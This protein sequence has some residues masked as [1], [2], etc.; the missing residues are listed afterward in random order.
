MS[1]PGVSGPLADLRVLDLSSLLPGPY[2]TRILADL[3]ADVI[4]IES[5]WG[6]GARRM[7]PVAN[8]CGAAFATL[9][10]DKRSVVIDLKKAEGVALFV[11][12]AEHVQVVVESFRPGVLARLQLGYDVLSRHNPAL[13]L[14][15]ISGFGQTGPLRDRAGHDLSYLARAGVLSLLGPPDGPPSVPGVQIADLGGGALSAAVGLLAALRESQRTG[16]GRHLD[17]AMTRSVMGFALME[18]TRSNTGDVAEPRGAGMLTGGLPCYRVYRTKD[19]RYMALAA[20][21]EKFFAAFCGC[22]GLPE[23]ASMGTATGS[24]GASVVARLETLFVSKTQAQ[25]IAALRDCDGCC[26]P[27]QTLEEAFADPGIAARMGMVD[28][29]IDVPTEPRALAPSLG[30]HGPEVFEELRLPPNLVAAAEAAGALAC[31]PTP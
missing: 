25:W 24:A 29:G 22:V 16:R 12:M 26:E 17:I 21:E 5:P 4:K 15:S 10:H 9:N 27:V 19:D 3:G 30:Q 6:D 7:P 2:L 20:L 14:C 23:L 28:V 13:I 8:G 11:A 1:N 31:A 18:S